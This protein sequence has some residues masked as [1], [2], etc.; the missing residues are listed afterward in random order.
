[1]VYAPEMRRVQIYL[2]EWMD[3]ALAFDALKQKT[4]KAALIRR[5]LAEHIQPATGPDPLDEIIG[6]IDLDLGG[7]SIDD[8]LYGPTE[9]G[10]RRRAT[11]RVTGTRRR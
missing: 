11:T 10:R 1:M 9:H 2:D 7:E 8:V 5:Y 6:S 3:D 4:T